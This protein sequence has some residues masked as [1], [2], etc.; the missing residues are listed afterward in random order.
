MD[1]ALARLGTDN[2]VVSGW[3]YHHNG[4]RSDDARVGHRP[5]ANAL[6]LTHV[7]KSLYET[8][9]RPFPYHK[10]VVPHSPYP[11]NSFVKLKSVVEKSSSANTLL[12]YCMVVC[13]VSSKWVKPPIKL[14]KM[15]VIM[16]DRSLAFF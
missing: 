7:K 16:I 4:H 10:V 9:L 5:R 8:Y 3:G 14:A 15:A 12:Y 13:Q 6:D 11:P 1:L 2:N